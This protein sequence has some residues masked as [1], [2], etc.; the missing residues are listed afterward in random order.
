M[1]TYTFP[2]G[3][4]GVVGFAQAESIRDELLALL[5]GKPSELLIDMSAVKMIDST[6]IGLI[7]A[8]VTT[9]A[10]RFSNMPII[11]DQVGP[12]VARALAIVRLDS[13]PSVV[14]NAVDAS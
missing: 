7:M 2:A 4:D 13:N 6:I 12:V 9:A 14:I 10:S 3:E 8:L 1:T 5:D 11:L